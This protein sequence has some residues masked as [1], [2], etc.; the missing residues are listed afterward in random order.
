MSLVFIYEY[1]AKSAS[2]RTHA[3]HPVRAIPSSPFR[4][5]IASVMMLEK[6]DLVICLKM[7]CYSK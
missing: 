5:F 4:S 2:K 3:H 1:M 7:F 6:I